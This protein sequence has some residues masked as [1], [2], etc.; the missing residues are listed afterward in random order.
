MVRNVTLR[1]N[2]FLSHTDPAQPLRAAVQGIGCFDG[3]FENWV[4]EDNI[5][6]LGNL[7]RH[8]PLWR[9]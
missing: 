1:G 8:R 5:I 4:I 9:H 3:L 6:S 7:P 2:R